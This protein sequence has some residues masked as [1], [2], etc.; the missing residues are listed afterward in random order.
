MNSWLWGTAEECI[1]Y[2]TAAIMDSFKLMVLVCVFFLVG[3]F[4][5]QPAGAQEGMLM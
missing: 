5:V 2:D 3:C 1:V 4:E